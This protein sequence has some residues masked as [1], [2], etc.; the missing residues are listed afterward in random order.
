MLKTIQASIDGCWDADE[1]E[2]NDDATSLPT[3]ETVLELDARWGTD[4]GDLH[5]ADIVTATLYLPSP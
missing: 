3:E 1:E 4:P 2:P 5:P